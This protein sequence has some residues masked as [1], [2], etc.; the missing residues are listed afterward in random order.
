MLDESFDTGLKLA[1]FDM[2]CVGRVLFWI[3]KD[4]LENSS[5]PLFE[6]TMRVDLI[7]K[8]KT[9]LTSSLM[10]RR[11]NIESLCIFSLYGLGYSEQRHLYDSEDKFLVICEQLANEPDMSCE[12]DRCELFGAPVANIINFLRP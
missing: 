10:L 11:N 6:M 5:E 4:M 1:C 2:K 12:W 3:E 8:F 7:P 9:F